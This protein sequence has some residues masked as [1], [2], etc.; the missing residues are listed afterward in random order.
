MLISG[1]DRGR[2]LKIGDFGISKNLSDITFASARSLHA[3]SSA[4]VGLGTPQYMAPELL[5]LRPKYSPASDVFAF[6]VVAWELYCLKPPFADCKDVHVLMAAVRN[7]EREDCPPGMPAAPQAMIELSWH[8]DP[9]KRPSIQQ[10]VIDL[11]AM[12]VQEYPPDSATIPGVAPFDPMA[13]AAV[14]GGAAG[15]Q[16]LRSR[17]VGRVA[18]A[19]VGFLRAF[20]T[21]GTGNGQFQR[22]FGVAFDHEGNVVV[23]EMGNSRIQVLRYSDGQH[24]RT[25]SQKG[26]FGVALDG[27]GH[28]VMA[29]HGGGSHVQVLNY[30]PSAAQAAAMAN[31]AF[32][33]AS[34]STLTATSS[35][36]TGTATAAFKFSG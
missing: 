10:C 12:L 16:I 24:L 15:G 30:A 1:P 31:A 14:G 18:A 22:P 5:G 27:A 4:A 35:C 11:E 19:G 25:I 26:A 29:E 3:T 9:S 32:P 33:P 36:M 7:G 21:K 17:N 8:Q 2:N 20:G 34:P 23:S 13:P 28:L 6:G